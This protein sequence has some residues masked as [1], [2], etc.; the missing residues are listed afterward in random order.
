MKP[1][2]YIAKPVPEPVITYM[3]E[4]CDVHM[5][6][7]TEPIPQDVLY[8]EIASVDGVLLS[9]I[10]I[11]ESFLSAASN[12]KIVCNASVGYDNFDIEAMKKYNVLGTH[13]PGVLDDTVADLVFG[14]ILT[15]ARRLAELDRLVKDGNWEKGSDTPLFGRDVHHQTLGIIGLGRIGEKLVKRA[16]CGFD[17]NVL[18]YNRSRKPVVEE[19]YDAKYTALDELLSQSDFV[20]LMTPLNPETEKMIGKRE[21]HLMK[22]TAFFINGSRGGTVDEQALI[23]ALQNGE[24]AG[25]GLDVFQQEPVDSNNPLLRMPNVVTLPHIGS[26]TA[27]TRLDMAM[28]AAQNLVKGVTGEIPPNVVPELKQ[29]RN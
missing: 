20:V 24:I 13:T 19:T 15:S 5:W 17:M 18:Y 8:E 22:P 9:H 1:K 25:A 16:K 2:V 29:Q 6:N 4:H 7:S 12:L 27:Q 23:D 14:L 21:F 26:A 10:D 11:N 28:L 3:S